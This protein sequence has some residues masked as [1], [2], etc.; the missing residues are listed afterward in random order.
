MAAVWKIARRLPPNTKKQRTFRRES[1]NT[2]IGNGRCWP[3][4][5]VPLFAALLVVATSPAQATFS[6][7]GRPKHLVVSPS[8]QLSVSLIKA[9]GNPAFE[10]AVLCN[11][12]NTHNDIQAAG[13]RS[14][15]ALLS[16]AIAT[17]KQVTFWFNDGAGADCSPARFPA[18]QTMSTNNNWYFGPR[19]DD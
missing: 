14:I 16:M 4:R 9:D 10:Y 5:G 19:L 15:Q 11:V 12:Q 13:C 3:R 6:C 8:G 17:N 1:M 18:W 7:S 2:K